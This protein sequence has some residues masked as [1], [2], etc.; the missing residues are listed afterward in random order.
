MHGSPRSPWDSKDLWKKYNYRDYGI[1][2]EP[3]FDIDFSKV[4]YLTDT[5]R[6][7]DGE[8]VSVRDKVSAEGNLTDLYKFHSTSDTSMPL[9][10]IPSPTRSCSPSIP[11]DGRQA[12]SLGP[13]T[14]NAVGE[15]RD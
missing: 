4:L 9:K 13:G 10:I 14:D 11:S 2:G 12:L 15:K 3:Y 8:K 6:H 1:I 7:W 5:G